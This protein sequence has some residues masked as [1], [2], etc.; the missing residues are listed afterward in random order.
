MTEDEVESVAPK[1]AAELIG[2]SVSYIYQLMES[3]ELPS[4][5]LSRKMRRIRLADIRALQQRREIRRSKPETK[6]PA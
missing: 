1:R 4:H 6:P 2:C 3:G 5:K